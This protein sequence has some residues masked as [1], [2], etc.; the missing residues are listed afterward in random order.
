[1]DYYNFAFADDKKWRSF[2]LES[3][4]GDQSMYGYVEKDSEVDRKIRI[5]PESKQAALI[6]KVRFPEGAKE[7]SN[8]VLIDEVVNEGWVE[9][10]P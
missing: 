4:K 6:L 5:S 3:L 9:K 1:V 7:D 8:Q 10:E 2:R